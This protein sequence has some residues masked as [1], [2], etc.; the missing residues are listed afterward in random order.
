M[1][2]VYDLDGTLI[3]T[4]YVN[5][6]SYQEAAREVCG[7][8]IGTSNK[9]F[10]RE[11]LINEYGL[12][13]SI[14]KKITTLK[15]DIFISH[16]EKTRLLPTFSILKRLTDTQNVLL[17]YCSR[18]RLEPIVDYYDMSKLFNY[19]F[20][21]ECYKGVSKFEFIKSID[22]YNPQKVIVFEN[23]D[24][25]INEAI[26]SGIPLENIFQIQSQ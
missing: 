18:Y 7:I 12:D 25:S 4:D 16:I 21:K 14:V 24:S 15:Q 19:V 22:G 5:F 13:D 20:F 3:D 11:V 10:T 2:T 26:I 1:Y 17:T 8:Q 6:I 9:R 23:E